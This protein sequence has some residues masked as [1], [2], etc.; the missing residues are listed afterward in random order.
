MHLHAWDMPPNFRLTSNDLKFH[1]Y[2]IEYPEE[3][4]R[5]KVR[6]MTGTLEDV[7]QEKMVS[8]RAGR[9]GFNEIYAKVLIENGYKVDCSVTPLVSWQLQMGDPSRKGG[10]DYK[11][12]PSEPYFVDLNDISLPGESLLLELPMTIVRTS[13]PVVD[14]MRSMLR[15]IAP[16]RRMIGCFFEEITWFRPKIDNLSKMKKVVLQTVNEG[17][18]YIEFMIHSSELMPGGSPNFKTKESIETLYSNLEQVFGLAYKS[19][20]GCTMKEFH[21]RFMHADGKNMVYGR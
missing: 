3:I 12:F 6:I 17:K 9:W 16:V 11:N 20:Q 13:P 7:F 18:T 15:K 21:A 14:T 4:I 1:P 10:T 5:E 19:F 8:H 2:L